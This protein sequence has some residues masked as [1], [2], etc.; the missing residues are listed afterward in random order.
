M[1]A[2]GRA[3]REATLTSCVQIAHKATNAIIHP[4]V[5]RRF[6]IRQSLSLATARVAPDAGP[7]VGF[8]S[9]RMGR[10]LAAACERRAKLAAHSPMQPVLLFAPPGRPK[11]KWRRGP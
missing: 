8:R 3:L 9:S 2:D 1:P 10:H 11:L 5:A 6:D 4:A 7:D